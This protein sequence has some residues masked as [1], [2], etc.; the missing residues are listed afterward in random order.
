MPF[1]SM[2][3]L[4]IAVAVTIAALALATFALSQTTEPA[5]IRC[6]VCQ[7]ENTWTYKFCVNC[8]SSL[9]AAKQAKL[10]ELQREQELVRQAA[11]RQFVEDS[12]AQARAAESLR[13][14]QQRQAAARPVAPASP[15]TSASLIPSPASVASAKSDRPKPQRWYQTLLTTPAVLPRLFNVPTAE[16]LNSLD[17]YF[18][19]GGAFGIEK[20]RN[21]LG[22]AGLGLGD[23]AEVEFATQ[24]VINSLQQGSSSVSTSAFKMLVLREQ[25][26]LP[27]IA[28][29]LRGTTSWHHFQGQDASVSFE[30]RLTKLYLVATKHRGKVMAHFGVGL[31]DV[32]VRSPQG[33]RFREAGREMQRNLIAPFGG[34]TIQA[35]PKAQVMLEVEGLPSYDFTAGEVHDGSAIKNI[36]AGVV[37]VRFYF[38]NWLAADTGVRY[39]SDFDGIA[40]ANIQANVNML[41]PLGRLRSKQ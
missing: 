18:N 33:W 25:D 4:V 2:K 10:Q 11:R 19:G 13:V 20:E 37:G 8:G 5:S 36:W 32:R 6:S 26:R 23:I 17:I 14:E 3:S 34:L 28:V 21:F 31:T 15:E 38:T 7:F 12:L 27:A 41:F 30:T 24:A 39:R 35:N 40:D 16:V 9:A 29:S 1:R 22:H